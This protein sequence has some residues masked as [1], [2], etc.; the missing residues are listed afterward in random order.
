MCFVLAPRG[1]PAVGVARSDGALVAAGVAVGV[2]IVGVVMRAVA[3]LVGVL[4]H[5]ATI[6]S[7]LVP[8]VGLV[9]APILCPAMGVARSDGALVAA[10][11][12]V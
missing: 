10:G 2:G 8:M 1:C 9:L 11:R 12:C 7:A 5:I 3:V 4:R 6:S